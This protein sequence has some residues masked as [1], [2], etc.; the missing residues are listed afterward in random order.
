MKV[1]VQ[2]FAGTTLHLNVRSTDTIDML[3]NMESC[4]DGALPADHQVMM[5]LRNGTGLTMADMH[6]EDGAT[7]FVGK[8]SMCVQVKPQAGNKFNLIIEGSDTIAMIK[9]KIEP[10]TANENLPDGIPSVL[11][12]LRH[13]G[14][15]LKD[16]DK[17]SE[18]DIP[19]FALLQLKWN[20]QDLQSHI[21]GLD[22][23]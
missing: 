7:L 14:V 13:G 4:A 9:Q 2:T 22:G 19:N 16:K 18:L 11:M 20:S 10:M 21:E 3:N 8:T 15:D 6:I 1:K 23:N 12:R 5:P 17:F